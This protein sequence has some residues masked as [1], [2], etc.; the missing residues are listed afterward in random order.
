MKS[1][2]IVH[3]PQE[4][5][6]PIALEL[7]FNLEAGREADGIKVK[8]WKLAASSFPV[9]THNQPQKSQLLFCSHHW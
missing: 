1:T 4:V 5:I 6:F 3:P 2:I 9:R 8:Y 7:Y